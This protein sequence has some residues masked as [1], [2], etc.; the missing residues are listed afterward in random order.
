MSRGWEGPKFAH[1]HCNLFLHTREFSLPREPPLSGVA[2]EGI[3]LRL[4]ALSTCPRETF[5][6]IGIYIVQEKVQFICSAKLDLLS[7]LRTLHFDH[8]YY[9]MYISNVEIRPFNLKIFLW[10]IWDNSL[11]IIKTNFY[12]PNFQLTF[13]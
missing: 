10:R 1:C 8:V 3:H 7:I 2:M 11:I 13:M 5:F 4:I 12:I 6:E 9:F